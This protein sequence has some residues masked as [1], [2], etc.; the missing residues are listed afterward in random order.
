MIEI[1][2]DGLGSLQSFLKTVQSDCVDV[3]IGGG[4]AVFLANS[5]EIFCTWRTIA[6]SGEERLRIPKSILAKLVER[7][8]LLVDVVDGVVRMEMISE[9]G[10]YCTVS[11]AKQGFLTE[12]YEEKLE[13]LREREEGGEFDLSQF[14][15][16]YRIA[17]NTNSILNVDGGVAVVNGT[18]GRVYQEVEV[19]E[20][21][22]LTPFAYSV[23]TRCSNKVRSLDNFLI[24]ESNSLAVIATKC[25]SFDNSEYMLFKEQKAAAVA[26]I[27]LGG[28]RWFASKVK[29]SSF[30]E[31]NLDRGK[32]RVVTDSITYE[33]PVELSNIVT[34][35][36]NLGSLKLPVCVMEEFLKEL[37]SNF[38]LAKKKT[39]TQLRSGKIMVVF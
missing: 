27:N 3:A 35:N 23:L 30:L 14:K 15:T 24:A 22:A 32:A 5:P 8:R 10:T 18:I 36:P 7:G 6:S 37:G 33:I 20:R 38:T 21:F 12:L 9:K 4:S 19:N 28:I 13:L 1:K 31:I 25:K 34:K 29:L 39:F 16:L 2:I 11:F 26:T 17:S